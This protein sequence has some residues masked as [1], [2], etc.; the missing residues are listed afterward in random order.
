VSDVRDELRA[1][2]VSL[3][4]ALDSIRV[5]ADSLQRDP[6]ALLRGARADTATHSKAP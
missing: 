5:L 4:Q 3:R 6:S 1:S 2:L